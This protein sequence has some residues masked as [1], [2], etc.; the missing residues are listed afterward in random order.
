MAEMFAMR[1]ANGEL[2]TLDRKGRR[3]LP[4]FPD[5]ETAAR[6]W[7]LNPELYVFR[8]QLIDRKV[9]NQKIKPAIS[10]GCTLLL[11]SS[12]DHDARWSS[13]RE[14]SFEELLNLC[15]STEQASAAIS[16][17]ASQ[18]PTMEARALGD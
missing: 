5:K 9:I 15:G 10:S 4:V 8:S 14:I 7:S 18:Q 13:G 16:A 11:M 1:R 3:Y 17:I 12:E 6:Y 2:F